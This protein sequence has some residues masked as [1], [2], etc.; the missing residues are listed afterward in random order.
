MQERDPEIDIL[1]KKYPVVLDWP[2]AWGDMDAFQHVNNVKYFM[3]FENVRVEYGDRIG[4]VEHME[5]TGI[6]PI[7]AD[8]HMTYLRPVTYPD[9]LALG[10]RV[11]KIEPTQWRM[12]FRAVSHARKA[13]VASGDCITVFFD[14]NNRKRAGI[15]AEIV[16]ECEQLEGCSFEI[17]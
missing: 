15:P 9:T 2:V 7:L 13:V 16:A 5:K 14:Y 12:D 11:A 17:E 4:L 1:L 8:A 10:V 6:G 3:Y